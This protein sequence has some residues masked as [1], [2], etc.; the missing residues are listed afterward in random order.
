MVTF[1]R[2]LVAWDGS[3]AAEAAL[4]M[5][6]SYAGVVGA[7]VEALT[8]FDGRAPAALVGTVEERGPEYERVTARFHTRFGDGRVRFHA[9]STRTNPGQVIAQYAKD[10]GFDLIAVGRPATD[11]RGDH[12]HAVEV[13]EAQATATVLV[14]STALTGTSPEGSSGGPEIRAEA[15]MSDDLGRSHGHGRP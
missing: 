4:Q 7:T 13:L 2:I 15:S 9:I 14:V 3:D 6:T 5:A 8:V 11:G 10:R 1:G 12:D